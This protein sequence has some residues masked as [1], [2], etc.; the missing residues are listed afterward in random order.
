MITKLQQDKWLR[1]QIEFLKPLILFVAGLYFAPIIFELSK[2]D[3]VVSLAD[4][5]PSQA[6]V[7]ATVLYLINAIYDFIRK[8][9]KE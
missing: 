8:W 1:N 4:F 7:T 9:A 5:K 2:A 6:V 3:H